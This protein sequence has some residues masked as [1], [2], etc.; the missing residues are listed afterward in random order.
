[1]ARVAIG[2]KSLIHLGK[3]DELDLMTP[4]DQVVA[5]V[6]LLSMAVCLILA[7]YLWFSNSAELYY[8]M[9]ALTVPF[10]ILGLMYHLRTKAWVILFA[11]ILLTGL[12]LFL[13][14]IEFITIFFVDFVFVGS[15]GVVSLVVTIQ[16]FIFY[17]VVRITEYMNIKER[18]TFPEKIVAFAFNIPRDLD[19]RYITMDH[20]KGRSSVPWGDILETIRMG[21]MIG[22]FIW[23][24]LSMN[25]SIFSLESFIDAPMCIF[26]IVLFIPVI[27]MPWTIFRSLNVRI[28]TRYR[29]FSLYSGIKETLKRM[30]LP[31]FAAFLFVLMAVNRNG[32]TTVLGFIAFSIAIIVAII[33]LTA[34]IYYAFFEKRLVDQIVSKW[35]V[36]RPVSL[37]AGIDD[38]KGERSYPGTPKRDTGNYDDLGFTD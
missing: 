13:D 25:P 26:T 34:L 5:V 29:D 16:K 10:F 22:I 37:L 14:V 12:A 2:R 24:Y 3:D 9:M 1:M 20:F 38:G 17:R 33:V 32:L 21:L 18:M 27:V 4:Y 31:T 11:I 28:E 23:I 30:V 8:I 7:A 35:S 15:V 19:T 36:Y 6:F